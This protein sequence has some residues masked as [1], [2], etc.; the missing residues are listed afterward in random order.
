M[1]YDVFIF[2][3][4]HHLLLAEKKEWLKNEERGSN[5]WKKE[6]AIVNALKGL[7]M[8]SPGRLNENYKEP[9]RGETMAL[10]A[11]WEIRCSARQ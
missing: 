8:N 1:D 6:G 9:L 3:I 11:N 5:K 10:K 7:N 2:G 4:I